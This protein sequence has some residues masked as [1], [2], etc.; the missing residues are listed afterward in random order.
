MPEGLLT[1]RVHPRLY[2]DSVAL[3]SIASDLE[4]IDG[5][6][7]AGA[8]MATP[9]N[10]DILSRSDM[11]PSDL[12][13]EPDDLLI[14][15]RA[16]SEEVANAALDEADEALTAKVKPSEG[17]SLAYADKTVDE[18]LDNGP[19]ELVTISVPGNYAGAVAEQALHRGCHVF[20][21]SDNVAIE[22]ENRLKTLAAK[23]GLLLMG[24]DCG[25]AIIDGTP[26]G[27]ANTLPTGP[28]G[29]I[30]A[31]GTG[32]QEVSTLAANAGIGMAHIIGV[33]GRDLAGQVD[34]PA[35]FVALDK[36]NDDDAIELIVIVSKPPAHNVADE[37][38]SRLGS[39]SKPA[40]ACL[41]GEDD[42]DNGVIVRGTLEGAAIAIAEHFGKTI[43]TDGPQ[44]DLP[45]R[46]GTV[47]GLYTGGTLAHEAHIL[48]DRAKVKNRVIDLGD[49]EYTQGRPH[50]MISPDLRAA[51]IK[52]S[53]SDSTMS[54]L[55]VDVVIGW[56]SSPD[57]ATPVA[58]A[59]RQARQLAE[60]D[61]RT[62]AVFASIT[63]TEADHQGLE[64]QRKVLESA[65]ITVYPT[66]AAAVRAAIALTSPEE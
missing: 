25:T 31:S 39:L 63:G 61:G 5:V 49:D 52:D 57:P 60:A 59:V 48:L 50:P 28:V 18:A 17:G 10:H 15:V 6:I 2:R 9:A 36:L 1:Y 30:A 4:K 20:C 66:N 46:E 55:L 11:L 65:G 56:G 37:L 58:E 13:A 23:H 53:G 34:D 54:A 32:A 16:R 19:A 27:F 3:M 45:R 7:Q 21:F 22:D 40:I 33:G 51:M 43:N 42:S 26:L 35:T 41:L 47:V 12:D 64:A 14:V 24:P 44:I 62:L 8:V 29:M 38:I